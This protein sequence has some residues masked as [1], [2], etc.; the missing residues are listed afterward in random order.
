MK[1][2]IVLV[3]AVAIAVPALADD[4]SPAPFRGMPGSMYMEWSYDS[5]AP[6][7]EINDRWDGAEGNS[8]VPHP[9]KEDPWD[10]QGDYEEWG[11]EFLDP[12]G[13][14]GLDPCDPVFP[15]DYVGVYGN[16]MWAGGSGIE[17]PLNPGEWIDTA[18][19][20]LP[21]FIGRTGVMSDFAFGSWDMSNFTHDQ[22]AKDMWVQITYF[23]LEA[24]GVP[25]MAEYDPCSGEMYAGMGCSGGEETPFGWW[26]DPCTGEYLEGP[27]D[28][29]DPCWPD[30]LETWME[31]GEFWFQAEYVSSTV[32]GDNWIQDV[33]AVTAE[34]N[35]DFEWFEI[36]FGGAAIALDQIIIETLCYVPE[37][38]TM[39][40]LGLGSLLM[41]RRKRR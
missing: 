15:P 17:D 22:P 8:F 3:M 10:W 4:F 25:V 40:L 27:L 26:E 38:T 18:P 41:I 30:P 13:F 1:K 9:E 11:Y 24:P 33:Y 31:G 19:A 37:P 20:W 16:Q 23:N 12:C 28:E 14:A 34:L 7:P 2:L 39:V 21:T 29:W 32:L 36:G 35:P 6:N 5:D